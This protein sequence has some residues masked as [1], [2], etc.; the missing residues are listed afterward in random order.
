MVRAHFHRAKNLRRTYIKLQPKQD[1]FL[2]GVVGRS[3]V[4]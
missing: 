1:Q 2:S 3:S 4:G